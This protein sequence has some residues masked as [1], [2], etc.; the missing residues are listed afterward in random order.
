MSDVTGRI[1]RWISVVSALIALM[2]VFVGAS[3]YVAPG[4]FVKG[5]DFSSQRL[6]M[7]PQMWAARQMAIAL[8]IGYSTLKQS[9]PMLSIALAAYC[10]MT[11]QDIF[12]GL[13]QRDSGVVIGSAVGCVLSASMVY[14][15]SRGA[16]EERRWADLP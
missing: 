8:I 1:P 15:L 7:L 3:L 13:G 4:A 5:I 6:L 10:A 11:F 14:V 12:I 2:G 9:I 16:R